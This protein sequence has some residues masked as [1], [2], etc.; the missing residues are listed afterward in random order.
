MEEV[1]TSVSVEPRPVVNCK[2]EV[3]V[4]VTI[5]PRRLTKQRRLHLSCHQSNKS[6][7]GVS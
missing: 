4:G 6:K 7:T 5:E 2:V 3:F 1:F